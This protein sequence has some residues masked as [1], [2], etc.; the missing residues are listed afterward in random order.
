MF[1]NLSHKLKTLRTDNHLSRKQVAERI[2]VTPAMVALYETGDR[3]PSLTVI[4][5]LSALYK[6]SV[7]YLLDVNIDK[8]D[9]V[10][11]LDGLSY[12]QKK[13]LHDVADCYRKLK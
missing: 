9:N 11:S 8:K 3:L 2:G 13:T 6:V 1:E 4:V 12:N 5:K 7:D 10:L